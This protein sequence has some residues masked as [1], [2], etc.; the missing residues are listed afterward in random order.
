MSEV[1]YY[2]IPFFVL[3]L[4]VEGLTYRHLQSD[5]LVG[6]ELHDT[7]T[8]LAMGIGNVTVNVVWKFAVVA[9]YAALYDLPAVLAALLLLGFA[10]W[11]VLRRPPRPPRRERAVPRP[12]LR[13]H[14]RDLGPAV[15]ELRAGGR[16]R[17]LRA[18]DEHRHVQPGGY[19][20]SR[21]SRR[22]LST[23]PSVWSR[24][25]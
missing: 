6:Y 25:Q 21:D 5:G 22:S 17:A 12:Q 9:V 2:A 4:V 13:R 16:A 24:G 14:P 18:D 3:L 19:F 1:L 8:S 20:S 11:M 15:R 23:R 10:P 7:R